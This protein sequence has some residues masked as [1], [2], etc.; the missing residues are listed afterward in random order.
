MTQKRVRLAKRRNL[1]LAKR[2]LSF[3]GMNHNGEKR[4]F[5]KVLQS[6]MSHLS[7]SIGLIESTLEEL[8]LDAARPSHDQEVLQ[9]EETRKKVVHSLSVVREAASLLMALSDEMKTKN[10]PALLNNFSRRS[11]QKPSIDDGREGE[12]S[13][14]SGSSYM[15]IVKQRERHNFLPHEMVSRLLK[16]TS[17]Q[18]VWRELRDGECR[19]RFATKAQLSTAINKLSSSSYEGTPVLDLCDVS[20]KVLSAY[21][22]R[23]APIESRKL[24]SWYDEQ[25]TLMVTKAINQLHE[26]NVNWFPN[27]DVEAIEVYKNGSPGNDSRKVVVKIFLSYHAYHHFLR[28]SRNLTA[29]VLPNGISPIWED[30]EIV[31]CWKCYWYGH[32]SNSCINVK[33]RYCTGDHKVVRKGVNCPLFESPKCRNCNYLNMFVMEA[34]SRGTNETPPNFPNWTIAN[35]DHVVTSGGCK[36]T[37]YVKNVYLQRLKCAAHNRLPLP[38]FRWP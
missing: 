19:I 10:Q 22:I 24:V 4:R 36:T 17:C 30:V 14:P 5:P 38:D 35:I 1:S 2:L 6:A 28:T 20:Q 27:Q 7:S 34:Q 33:C 12:D 26:D 32:R 25:G 21:S 29:I 13:L 9:S 31:Q 15:L 18:Q 37:Q 3:V 16:G 8:D 11:S 23:T